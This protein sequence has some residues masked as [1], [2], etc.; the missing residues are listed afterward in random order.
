MLPSV[1]GGH[2]HD[3]LMS[4]SGGD[5][6]GLGEGLGP[7]GGAVVA[8]PGLN[9]DRRFVCDCGAPALIRR[10]VTMA[11]GMEYMGSAAPAV[12][13]L[14]FT[15]EETKALIRLRQ[16]LDSEFRV[17]TRKRGLFTLYQRLA[18]ELYAMG[19][20]AF[21]RR[22]HHSVA[23]RWN[24]IVGSYKVRIKHKLLAAVLCALCPVCACVL[25]TSFLALLCVRPVPSRCLMLCI[26]C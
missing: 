17:I 24:N 22:A 15:E 3:G 4:A 25:S 18:D 16:S 11:G 1:E 5:D 2:M 8:F 9:G 23:Q 21:P 12:E 10:C 7:A 14:P 19:N 6:G 26:C 13:T 20:G